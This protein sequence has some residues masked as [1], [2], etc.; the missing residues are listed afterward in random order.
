[1]DLGLHDR[2]AAVAGASAG[3]GLASAR[4]L[5][6]EGVRV[7]I[8]GRDKVRIEAAAESLP[9]D[10]IPIVADVG[11]TDGA[12]AF[13]DQALERLGGIDIL[14]ANA[15]GPPPGNFATTDLGAYRDAVDLNLLSVV[16][17]CQG[18]VP[19]MRSAQ[20]GRVLAITS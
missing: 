16:A 12:S 20:W 2:R 14:V 15:G 9:G 17:M 19:A 8:C 13:V 4:A 18:V 6:A 11:T 7:A 10:P 5:A 3:L 1:M